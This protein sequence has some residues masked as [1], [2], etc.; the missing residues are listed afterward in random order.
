MTGQFEFRYFMRLLQGLLLPVLVALCP[1]AVQASR[2]NVDFG[3]KTFAPS[4]TYGAA[5]GQAGT[6]NKISTLGTTNN[7]L[8]ISGSSTSIS[9]T[10]SADTADG[11]GVILT[12]D[13]GDLRDD[14]FYV[15]PTHVW[16]VTF[17]NLGNATYDLYYYASDNPGVPTGVFSA[18][19]VT[20]SNIIGT[21]TAG[22][23]EGKDW[24]VLA[25]VVVN[26][27][28]LTLTSV[29]SAGYA[30]LAGLQLVPEENGG[31]LVNPE[32][33]TLVLVGSLLGLGIGWRKR[34]VRAT[35]GR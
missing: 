19:G 7:L 6:W 14:N 29:A 15:S 12:G 32:P 8:D 20:A 27:G 16:S 2:I 23:T 13:T 4:I 11:Y 5:S 28:T 10:V 24:E 17:S 21:N 3:D 34:S 9:I 33:S 35:N 30:G 25:G 22:L 31:L 26:D 1:A 18:N